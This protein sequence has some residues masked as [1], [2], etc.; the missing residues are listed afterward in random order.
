M[1]VEELLKAVADHFRAVVAKTIAKSVELG[2]EVF[3][4]TYTKHL[5]ALIDGA[6]H[7][8]F[9]VFSCVF[10]LGHF[11]TNVISHFIHEYHSFSGRFI[12][13]S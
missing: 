8:R 4:G 10:Y 11:F 13:H 12:S 2:D 3:G 1:L 6:C 9:P 5:I 7:K